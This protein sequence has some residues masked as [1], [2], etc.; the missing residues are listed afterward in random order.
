MEEKPDKPH[1]TSAGWKAIGLGIVILLRVIVIVGI[2]W[3]L[4][5]VIMHR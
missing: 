5:A 3:F 4:I 2:L 1:K